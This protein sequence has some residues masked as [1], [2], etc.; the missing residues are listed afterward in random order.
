ME[1]LER[2]LVLAGNR[3]TTSSED[4]VYQKPD[5]GADN[6][7]EDVHSV[8]SSHGGVAQL[9]AGSNT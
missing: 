6:G 5:R 4:S 8:R 7:L 2:K 1:G 3:S 9:E